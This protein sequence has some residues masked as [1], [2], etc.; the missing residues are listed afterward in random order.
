MVSAR[1]RRRE[2]AYARRR[3]LS[4][5]KACEVF[6]VARSMMT[7]TSRLDDKD[8]VVIDC[9][10]ALSQ[11]NPRYGYRRVRVLLGRE[12]KHMSAR[13]AHRLWNK[14]GLQVPK[15][16]RR[17]VP[18]RTAR[19]TPANGANHVWCYD[20][21]HDACAN[22]QQFKCLTVVDEYT[23]EC[24][25]IDVASSI[26]SERVIA[27][28]ARLITVHGPPAFVRSD[29]GPEF[30]AQAVQDWL[31]EEGI[32]T[33]YIAPGKPWQNG[34]NESF[35]GKLR[36]ECLDMEWFPTRREAVV[37]IEQYRQQY[38]DVRPH[39]SLGYRTPHEFK[40][41]LEPTPPAAALSL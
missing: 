30:I 34:L 12:G 9:M 14:A 28:L 36:D 29:N 22:G 23:R 38:N 16:R 31:K 18:V 25:A 6:H 41:L 26:R 19:P 13:R 1:G 20:F 33:A 40:K 24:L 11:A 35:N 10:A 4:L 5:T 3:G 27:V 7:Y 2:A 32:E 21:V 17:R 15:K 37:V 8:A 39:S